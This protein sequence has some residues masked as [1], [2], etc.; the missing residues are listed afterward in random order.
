MNDGSNTPPKSLS[1][2]VNGLNL[3][4]LDWG[5]PDAPPALLLHGL[6]GHAHSWDDVSSAL[7]SD[8][9][10]I[11]L[12]QRGRGETDWAPDGDYGTGAFAADIAGFVEALKLDPVLLIGH[13][14]GGRN[15]IMYASRNP[16]RVK[17]F[18]IADVGPEVQAEGTARIRKELLDSPEEYESFEAAL[19]QTKLE[20]PLA[21][22]A[23]LRRRIE[24]QTKPTPSGGVRWRYDPVIR[25]QARSNTR[26]PPPNFWPMWEAIACPILIVRGSETDILSPAVVERMLQSNR[27]ASVVEV[28][29]ARHMVYEDNP[30]DFIRAVQRWLA[31]QAL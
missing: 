5:S 23:V 11:A 29:R 6:R 18:V 13:S 27:R 28:P 16:Q 20:N 17:A 26:P 21:P 3:H 1:L 9:R 25:D 31:E 10:V 22:E 30:G 19:A 2:C 15:G 24:Y 12:D 14:M 4:Y 7:S 8:Y